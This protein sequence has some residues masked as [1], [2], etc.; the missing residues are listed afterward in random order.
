[1]QVRIAEDWRKHLQDEFDKPYFKQLTDFVREEYARKCFHREG[2][3]S[4]YSIT[5]RSTR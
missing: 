2:A 1:M 3:S 4:T 5:A